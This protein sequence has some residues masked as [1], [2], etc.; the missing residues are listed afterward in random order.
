MGRTKWEYQVLVNDVHINMDNREE[1]MMY[2]NAM[3]ADGWELISVQ[4]REEETMTTRVPIVSYI[5][6]RPAE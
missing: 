1:L 2:L 4:V 3:G 5:F 6:K